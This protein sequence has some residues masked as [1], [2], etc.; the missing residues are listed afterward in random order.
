MYN[1]KQE[2]KVHW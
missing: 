1:I 2:L